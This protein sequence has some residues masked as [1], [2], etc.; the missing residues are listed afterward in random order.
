MHLFTRCFTG[1]SG[2]GSASGLSIG[3]ARQQQAVELGSLELN[4]ATDRPI[5]ENID[6]VAS[7]ASGLGRNSRPRPT[8]RSEQSRLLSGWSGT[9]DGHVAPCLLARMLLLAPVERLFLHLSDA[10]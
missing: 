5:G 2:S 1:G 4:S 10:R 9:V 3:G 8:L 7:H 6:W